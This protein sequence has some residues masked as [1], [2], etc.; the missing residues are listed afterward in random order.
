MHYVDADREAVHAQLQRGVESLASFATQPVPIDAIQQMF[1]SVAGPQAELHGGAA[2]SQELL[3]RHLPADPAALG[4]EAVSLGYL[5]RV[6]AES[7]DHF[8]A[9]LSSSESAGFPIVEVDEAGKIAAATPRAEYFP[10]LLG[11][12]SAPEYMPLTG[13]DR[14]GDA[15]QRLAMLQARDSGMV[16]MLTRF[17]ME[18]DGADGADPLVTQYYLPV[19]ASGT[20][21][22][23]PEARRA[24]FTGLLS[25]ASY[26]SS[27][28]LFTLLSPAM[29]GIEAAYFPDSPLFDSDPDYADVRALIAQGTVAITRY[30]IS[31]QRFIVA[32]RA[33]PRLADVLATSTRWW[34]LCIGLL[35]TA[36]VASMSL[37]FRNQSK[38]I[39]G[40]V[41]ARTRDLTERTAALATANQALS[42]SESRYRMLA[43]NATDV[44]YTCDLDGRYTY[45]SPSVAVQRG[46]RPE[47]LIG[48]PIADLL[49]E[50]ERRKL[51]VRYAEMRENAAKNSHEMPPLADNKVEFQG[52]C[53]DGSLRWLETTVSFLHEPDGRCSGMLGVS[54]DISERKRAEQEKE[55]LE[56]AYRQAQKMEAIG[57]LAGGIAHDF[58]NLLTGIYGY[59]DILKTQVGA[60][61]GAHESID[62][63]EKAS[64][65]CSALHARAAWRQ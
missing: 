7:V 48:R 41:I 6:S 65:S 44:I 10:V 52:Y 26:Q 16:V 38:R 59:A 32:G 43:D 35:L 36:W 21:P 14:S 12:A 17:P 37:W 2:L 57:T 5:P 58:N 8:S 62:I 9:Q 25:A 56:E 4:F 23:T 3:Q 1:N 61:P 15:M 55:Q 22:A 49:P 60:N 50:N 24:Q 20:T 47:E 53:K 45:V 31:G 29:Q 19:Y 51:Q 46:F 39:K 13:L 42:E 40:L 34:V 54:R 63:I 28:D 33:S 18:A 30:D 27:G 64:A 11:T